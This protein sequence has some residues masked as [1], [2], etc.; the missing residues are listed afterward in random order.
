MGQFDSG[1][2]S[3][4]WDDDRS[5]ESSEL[6]CDTPAWVAPANGALPRLQTAGLGQL[7]PAYQA[8]SA[9]DSAA[10]VCLAVADASGFVE[11]TRQSD[12]LGVLCYQPL[13][14]ACSKPAD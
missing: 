9:A 10:S 2:A 14:C 8:G 4:G 5:G 6:S 1:L 12:L 13:G 7:G 11:Q 3:V